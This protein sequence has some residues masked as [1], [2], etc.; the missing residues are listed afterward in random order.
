MKAL[1]SFFLT[2]SLILGTSTQTFA[3]IISII[4]N[5]AEQGETLDIE[6][7]AANIDFT[8]GTNVIRM[9]QGYSDIYPNS[10]VVNSP[11]V[12]N[13]NFSFNTNHETGYY[14]L[15]IYNTGSGTTLTGEDGFYLSPDLTVAVLDSIFPDHASRGESVTLTLYG[16]NTNFAGTSA[17]NAIWLNRDTSSYNHEINGTSLNVLND[18]ILQA[19]FNFTYAHAVDTYS[20]HTSNIYDGTI[21]LLYAFDLSEGTN[22]PAI[23]SI[24]PDSATQGETLDIEVTAENIDFTQGTNVIRMEQGYANIYPNSFFANNPTSLTVNF[25]LNK[26]HNTGDYDF[27]L[28]NSFS[29]I[30]L[31]EEDGFYLRPDL[32]QA[33]L[34][35]ISPDQAQRGESV[36]LTLYGSNTNFTET[37]A[38]NSVW[39]NRSGDPYDHEINAIS[40]NPID[41]AT[42]EAQ[43]SF[44]YSNPVGLYSVLAYNNYDG[45]LSLLT[46]F[47]LLEGDNPPAILSVSP[48]T[49][50]QGQT[51]DIEVTAENIDFTQ[52]TVAIQLEQNIHTIYPNSVLVNNPTKLTV[53]FAF[54]TNHPTG[55]YDIIVHNSI[56]YVTLTKINALYL[57]SP[58]GIDFE[59]SDLYPVIYPNPV[60]AY[61]YI[62]QEFEKIQFYSIDGNLI[63]ETIGNDIDVTHLNRGLY[64][65]RLSNR[66]NIIVKKIVLE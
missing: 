58:V 6:V 30:T 51:L 2:L 63:Y 8:Q 36:T 25:S 44:T 57:K 38:S 23:L 49:V 4:P 43:F 10:F 19:Q 26:D 9:E 11:T 1:N 59:N 28:Y 20:I 64:I 61:L 56:P 40:I 29:G 34:V 46:A 13:I 31:I 62:N 17:S 52:G 48:D 66:E 18:T 12:I 47:Q 5:T 41:N 33:V 15:I 24:S 60:T 45:T 39:M 55:N 3:Q 65:V 7:T 16:S 37:G 22:P 27:I 21:S 14:D 42:L 35:S 54:I 50:Q 32:T 53:N